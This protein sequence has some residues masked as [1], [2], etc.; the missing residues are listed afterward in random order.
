MPKVRFH[1][2][3]VQFT[4]NQRNKV[5]GV[6]EKLFQHEKR[7][8]EELNYVFCTDKQLLEMNVEWLDHDT[9]TDIIT[10]DLS[11]PG[12]PVIGEV[13]ISID[14]VR[15]NAREFGVDFQDEL[16]RVIFHGALHLCGYKDKTKAEQ[17]RMRTEESRWLNRSKR[18]T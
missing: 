11:S 4:F 18:S 1:Y 13:Y 9:Y 17:E 16:R 2:A 14:R 6:I 8:L 7:K 12:G 3:N 5:K 10:F 15:E